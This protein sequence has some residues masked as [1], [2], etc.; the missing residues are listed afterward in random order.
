MAWVVRWPQWRLTTCIEGATT[1]SCRGPSRAAVWATPRS[2]TFCIL[3]WRTGPVQSPCGRSRTPTTRVPAIRKKARASVITA[4]RCISTHSMSR[5]ISSALRLA[6]RTATAAMP[7]TRAPTWNTRRATC[8][9]L[10]SVSRRT[11]QRAT[12]AYWAILMAFSRGPL[13]VTLVARWHGER[14]RP[15]LGR[16]TNGQQTPCAASTREAPWGVRIVAT[17]VLREARLRAVGIG[18][19]AF[20][21]LQLASLCATR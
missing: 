4:T 21:R 2:W 16:A 12:C 6:T 8:L 19:I 14:S 5:C 15:E 11:L 18:R 1:C 20:S 3:R 17:R 7:S 9:A 10:P 13:N